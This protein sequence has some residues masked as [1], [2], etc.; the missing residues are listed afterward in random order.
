MQ[1]LIKDVYPLKA[2]FR[3][4]EKTGIA[5]ELCNPFNYTRNLLLDIKVVRLIET[6]ES[7]SLRINMAAGESK[8]TV[9][10]L[11]PK[12]VE[13]EGYG[14]DIC[15]FDGDIPV[16][17]ISTSFDVA[18]DW[19][20]AARYGFLSDF[21]AKDMGD[22]EDVECLNKFHLNLVQFYDWMYRHD[23]L[24]PPVSEFTDLMGKKGNLDTI[25]EKVSLCHDYG[26]KAVA[27]GAVYAA[28]REFYEGH[29]AWGLYN[30]SGEAYDFIDIF[31]IMDISKESPWYR[32][33]IEQY[34]NAVRF[35]DFD[36]IHMDTY[37]YPKFGISAVDGIVKE[38]RLEEL[39]PLLINDTREKLE[40]EK[41]D[42]CLI[43]NNVG[44]WPVD[45]VAGAAQDAIYIEVWEPYE[46]YCHIQQILQWAKHLGKGK[47]VILAAYLKPFKDTERDRVKEAEAAAMILTSVI[48]ANGGYHLLLGEKNG[49]LTQGYYADYSKLEDSFVRVLRNYYDFI[50]RYSRILFDWELRD[51][52]MTHCGGENLE[53]VI[54]NTDITLYGEP[55]KVW[56]VI[57]EKPRLKTISFINLA[58]NSE[59]YWNKGKRKPVVKSGICVKVQV[60]R[61]PRAVYAASPDMNFGRPVILDYAVKDSDRGKVVTVNL[62]DLSVWNLLVMEF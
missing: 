58:G 57:R 28:S 7:I 13:Y 42:V 56:A 26:M 24:V 10:E 59:D 12:D 1:Q 39:F 55:D 47:P 21:D 5:L 53:Y 60:L 35:V 61:I 45:T 19:R 23:E 17:M 2:Q 54:E 44:N 50:V 8:K 18:D 46:R 9:V 38:K 27:Y 20:R 32:H 40:M 34:R 62:P 49:V 51:V 3:K 41:E 14:I 11:E 37:G 15:L 48:A 22:T 6:V 43:F 36:G 52:S 29:R 33:I 30:S 16:Q 31:K 4:N 25:R